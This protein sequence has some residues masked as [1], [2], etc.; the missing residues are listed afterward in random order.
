MSSF[1]GTTKNAGDIVT[2]AIANIDRKDVITN[3]GDF[4]T[5]G[6]SANAQ[7]F[8]VDA[9]I[10]AYVTGLKIRFI[11]GFTNTA[12]CTGNV[13]S[14]GAKTFKKGASF[15]LDPGDLTAGCEYE[16]VYDGTN[17]ILLNPTSLIGKLEMWP[18][19]AVPNGYLLADG[20]AVSRTT[21]AAL[22]AVL[23]P[24]VGVVTMT[25]ASPAVVSLTSHGLIAGDAFY[26]TTTGA[27]PTGVSA[28][29]LY[30]V[31]S[32]G[33][34]ANAFEFSAT[35]GGS[36]INSSGSQSG[37]HTAKRCPYGLGDGSTTFNLP[38]TRGLM[39]IGKSTGTFKNEGLTGGEEN[40]T[41]SASELASHTHDNSIYSVANPAG[42]SGGF[43]AGNT[44]SGVT[45][46]LTGG[47]S[48]G[49][50]GQAHNNMPPYLTIN[51][52]IKY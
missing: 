45:Y 39:M 15:D 52:I 25:I 48:S 20:T 3:A 9:Q 27:L 16:A 32:A 19:R 22:F 24:V 12:A 34:T 26:F 30:Y 41:L 7:T 43:N 31:I 17:L 49:T 21:Y 4:I 14:I 37:V 46:G 50:T 1:S 47:A 18:M 42:P 35:R 2:A 29:T 36:A 11:A 8:A 28:N 40:H 23:N 13:N 6:G 38:D 44:Q 33:L 5:S 10:T 51:F